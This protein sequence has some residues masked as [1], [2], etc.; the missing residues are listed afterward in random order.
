MKACIAAKLG[1]ILG[2]QFCLKQATE[3]QAERPSHTDP[4]A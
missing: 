4:S 2:A 1:L 3:S